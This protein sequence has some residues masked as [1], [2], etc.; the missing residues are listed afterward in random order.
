[1]RA[2]LFELRPA[3]MQ[4]QTLGQLLGLL[5]E[6][7]YARTR[8]KVSLNVEGDRTLP[9]HVT[10]ALHRIAQ[11]ALNNVAKHA[12]AT[13]VNVNLVCGPDGIVLRITDDGRGF[14]PAD[15]PPGHFGVEN[16]GDRARKI[17]ATFEVDSNPGGGTQVVVTW[18]QHEEGDT[19]A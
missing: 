6:A 8:A 16:M 17:G 11:E 2:L 19:Y 14:D 15:I 18:S 1:M 5:A 9:E 4:D 7:T 3:A 10:T 13:T 12:E